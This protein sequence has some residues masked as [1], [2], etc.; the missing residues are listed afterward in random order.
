VRSAVVNYADQ[1][2]DLVR[3]RVLSVSRLTEV[4]QTIDPYPELKDLSQAEKAEL[5]LDNV[6]IEPVDPI[7]FEPLDESTAFAIYYS[8]EHPERAA[9]VARELARLFLEYKRESRVEQATETYQFLRIR[10]DQLRLTVAQTEEKLAAFKSRFPTSL[11]EDRVRNQLELDSSERELVTVQAQLR[12]AEQ[13]EA[14][15]EVQLSQVNPTL[16]GAVTDPRTEIAT[17]KAQLAEAERK[18]TPDHP[19]VK[20][21]RRSIETLATSNPGA[22]SGSGG[23][24]DNPEYLRIANDLASSKRETGALRSQVGRMHGQIATLRGS[25][26]GA[27]SVEVEY[28]ALTR[29]VAAARQQLLETEEKLRNAELASQVETEQKG[30]QYT[31]IRGPGIPDTPYRPNRLSLILLGITLALAVG[32]GAAVLADI[33]DPTVRNVD[34]VR[35][36]SSYPVLANIGVLMNTESRAKQSRLRL[37]YVGSLA[38]GLL[39]VGISVARTLLRPDPKPLEIGVAT[40]PLPGASATASP[41][42]GG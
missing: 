24:A 30:E 21:L 9:V 13:R 29:E 33:F 31:M 23:Q 8:N 39:L 36:I 12:L 1:Q 27:P 4:V 3:R 25:L 5:L 38:A 15:L 28:A 40:E 10:A 37:V 19:M 32:V 35:E 6:Y 42:V 41:D 2:F 16:V 17:L 20:R 22:V 18:Y 7:T 34:D 14:A 26:V 11:P